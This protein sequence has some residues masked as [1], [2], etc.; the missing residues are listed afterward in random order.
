[1]ISYPVAPE[2]IRF[3]EE[4]ATIRFMEEKAQIPMCLVKE[5]VTIRY[6]P[7]KTIR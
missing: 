4:K 6:I 5:T 3:M 7:M 2:T 1:M